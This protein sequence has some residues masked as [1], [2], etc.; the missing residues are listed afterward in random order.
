MSWDGEVLYG[1]YALVGG[2]VG[3]LFSDL[4]ARPDRKLKFLF[5]LSQSMTSR[6]KHC[7]RIRELGV[8]ADDKKKAQYERGQEN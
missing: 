2:W 8:R 6:C 5:M 1:W 3:Y 7:L 4:F